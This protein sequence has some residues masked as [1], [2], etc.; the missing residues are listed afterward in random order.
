MVP[1]SLL[2]HSIQ[3][4]GKVDQKNLTFFSCLVQNIYGQKR[5]PEKFS[6][7]LYPKT[8]VDGN[9]KRKLDWNSGWIFL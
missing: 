3:F 1:W 8:S 6:Y 4:S 7:L 2:C 5:Y 9:C